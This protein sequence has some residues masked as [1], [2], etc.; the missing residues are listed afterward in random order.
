MGQWRGGAGGLIN[1]PM[2]PKRAGAP[3]RDPAA[4]LS[5]MFFEGHGKSADCARIGQG[6]DSEYYSKTTADNRGKTS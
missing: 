1:P 3:L 2:L 6:G 5:G 4:G